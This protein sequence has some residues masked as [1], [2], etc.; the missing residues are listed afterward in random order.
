MGALNKGFSH[1]QL[2]TSNI[3][4]STESNNFHIRL[5]NSIPAVFGQRHLYQ[6][7]WFGPGD[8]GQFPTILFGRQIPTS[9]P[10]AEVMMRLFTGLLQFARSPYI[11]RASPIHLSQHTTVEQLYKVMCQ[12]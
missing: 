5:Q 4:P 10:M 8:S 11:H 12:E 2:I 1:C 3:S 7:F 9:G 6:N